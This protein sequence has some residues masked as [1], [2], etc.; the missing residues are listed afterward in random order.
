[1]G[2]NGQDMVWEMLLGALKRLRGRNRFRGNEVQLRPKGELRLQPEYRAGKVVPGFVTI[3]VTE[4]LEDLQGKAFPDGKQWAIKDFGD[5]LDKWLGEILAFCQGG[6]Y[7]H[8]HSSK[9]DY[10]R[11][12]TG[13]EG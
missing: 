3:Y 5:D 4:R 11:T 7:L 9:A 6:P 12:T 8:T 1:M 2:E 13:T 10:R